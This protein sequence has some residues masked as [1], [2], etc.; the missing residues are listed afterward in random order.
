MHAARR[1]DLTR[2][3][4]RAAQELT[5]ISKRND[6]TVQAKAAERD[7]ALIAREAGEL[8][9]EGRLDV[10]CISSTAQL[11]VYRLKAESKRAASSIQG[12]RSANEYVLKIKAMCESQKYVAAAAGGGEVAAAAGGGSGASRSGRG[13]GVPA[14][15]GMGMVAEAAASVAVVVMD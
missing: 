8:V 2:V 12:E 1:C 13:S 14:V 5:R 10:A 9:A 3:P 11:D 4:P 7:R 15:V 6:R